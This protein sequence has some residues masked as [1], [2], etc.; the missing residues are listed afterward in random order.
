M[1]VIVAF[2][3]CKC[4]ELRDFLKSSLRWNLL[5]AARLNSEMLARYGSEARQFSSGHI[6]V[7]IVRFVYIWNAWL[8]IKRQ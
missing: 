5:N 6:Q 2:F 7:T 1:M 3:V 8:S 4:L